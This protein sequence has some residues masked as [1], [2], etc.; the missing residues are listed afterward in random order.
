MKKKILTALAAGAIALGGAMTAVADTPKRLI[1]VLVLADDADMESIPAS[2]YASRT[3]VDEL[4]EQMRP[5]GY[6]IMDLDTMMARLSWGELG[7]RV[8]RRDKMQMVLASCSDGISTVCPRMV[9]FVETRVDIEPLGA[10]IGGFAYLNMSGDIVDARTGASQ[11]K[12]RPVE[13]RFTTP[14]PCER[15]CASR[16]VANNA[17]NVAAEL[18]DSLR[19][20]LDDS[21]NAL[22]PGIVYSAPA[23]GVDLRTDYAV[24]FRNFTFGQTG[25]MLD[26]METQF[27]GNAELGDSENRSKYWLQ[28]Y[29]SDHS[30]TELTAM[31]YQLMA[32]MGYTEEQFRISAAGNNIEIAKLS[33]RQ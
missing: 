23:A 20:L 2:N 31:L 18:G 13:D 19:I 33:L 4:Q 10:G 27:G 6:N 30:N 26:I 9:A 28:N 29:T 15:S 5:Y 8:S 3:V 12:W 25:A 32:D 21:L 17:Y 1:N 16:V 24:T 14:Y 7:N 11:G 22:E